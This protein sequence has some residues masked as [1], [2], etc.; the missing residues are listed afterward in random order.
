MTKR[1]KDISKPKA[2]DLFAGAGGFSEG[3][4]QGGFDVVVAV[5]IDKWAAETYRLNHKNTVMI[6]EDIQKI[7]PNRLLKTAN[8]KKGEL[9]LLF[10]GPPCQGFSTI[11]KTRSLNDPRSKLMNEFIRMTRGLK[12]KVFYIEN[13]PGLLAYKDFF[14]L[15]ME[16]LEKCGYTVRCLMMDACSYGVPQHRKRIFLQGIR[17]DLKHLPRFPKPTHF[18]PEALK[19]NKKM[20]SQSSIAL[21]CFANNG[22][23]K[24]EVRD[25]YWNKTLGIQMNRK[26]A[27]FVFDYA[28][29][30]LLGDGIKSSIRKK[31][32]IYI[33][34]IPIKYSCKKKRVE[35]ELIISNL[36]LP[37]FK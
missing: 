34:E 15:L 18:S 26:T 1:H 37:P 11:S 27:G 23:A 21:E 3:V 14:N 10:G 9:A 7:T 32:K 22:F 13:V 17:K 29:G 35:K 12:P 8:I 19:A 31:R 6:E 33:K 30:K 20:F 16:K 2:I 28:I 24:E 25:L 4:K 36:K 5:E